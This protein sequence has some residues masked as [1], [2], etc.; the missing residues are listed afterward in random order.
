MKPGSL[1]ELY[2]SWLYAQVSSPKQMKP[3][4]RTFW[5][6]IGQLYSKEFVW[7]VPNDDN[8]AEDGRELRHEFLDDEEETADDDWLNLGCSVLELL[9]GLSRRLA[10]ETD[11]ESRDWFWVMVSNLGLLEHNDYSNYPTEK[12][13]DAVDSLIWRTYHYDGRG[14]LFPLEHADE[15]Q[16]DVEIWYQLNAYLLEKE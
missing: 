10:F 4:A 6:L 16:T 3:P 12:V 9:V 15:D 5:K 8:R 14:G 1:D 11:R 7:F 13:D 2:L